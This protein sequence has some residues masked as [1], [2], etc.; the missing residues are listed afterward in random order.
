LKIIVHFS[1]QVYDLKIKY[2][3]DQILNTLIQDFVIPESDVNANLIID[4]L[5]VHCS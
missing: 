1:F 2:K 3:I 4:H 5:V